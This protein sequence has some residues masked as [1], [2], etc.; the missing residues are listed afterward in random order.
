MRQRANA[1][2]RKILAEHHPR[3]LSDQQVDELSRMALAFQT[4]AIERQARE[5]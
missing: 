3:P 4:R 1:A 5:G 2:A